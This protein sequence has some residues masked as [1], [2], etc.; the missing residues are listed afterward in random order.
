[1]TERWESAVDRQIREAQERGDWDGLPGLGKPLPDAG[2][3]YEEDWWVRDWA[4]R[5]QATG[6]LPATLALRREVEDLPLTVAAKPSEQA[7]RAYLAEVDERIR[8]ARFGHLDGPPVV[9]PPVDTEA[10]VRH[11]RATAR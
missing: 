1:M 10:L 2:A 11:W 5:E 6:V 8:Q 3:E 7:V 4:R 9:L